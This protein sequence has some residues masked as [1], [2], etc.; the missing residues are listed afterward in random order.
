MSGWT[1]WRG[2][3]LALAVAAAFAGGLLASDTTYHLFDFTWGAPV[4]DPGTAAV[5]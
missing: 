5:Q 1:R 2:A 4:F 3:V